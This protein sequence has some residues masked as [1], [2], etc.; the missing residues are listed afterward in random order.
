MVNQVMTSVITIGS[1]YVNLQLSGMEEKLSSSKEATEKFVEKVT[2]Q[3]KAS[4]SVADYSSGR[5]VIWKEVLKNLNIKGH[6]SREHIITVRNGDVGNN[7]HNTILQFAYDNGIQTGV[8]FLILMI[9]GGLKLLIDY[10]EIKKFGCLR[11]YLLLVHI[12]FGVTAMFTT[13]NLPFLYLVTLSYY[14]T[15]M[16]LFDEKGTVE[17]EKYIGDVY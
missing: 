4:S 5:T 1:Q 17:N 13:L 11:L 10:V 12:G 16:V 8:L 14:F 2:G 9:I 6:P 7:A 15:Y 3:D